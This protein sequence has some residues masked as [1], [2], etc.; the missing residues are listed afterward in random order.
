MRFKKVALSVLFLV[1]PFYS[2]AA[3]FDV[4]KETIKNAMKDPGSTEFRSLRNL[5]NSLGDTYVCGEVNSKNSY[6]GYV[7]FKGF[8]YK[9]GKF[10]IDGSFEEPSDAEFYAVSGCGGRD[11]EKVAIARKQATNGCK[12]TWEQITDIVLFGATPEK[13]AQNAIVK[14]K[15]I[16]PEIPPDQENQLKASFVESISHTLNDQNFVKSVKTET[17]AT[18]QA[19]MSGCIDATS[20]SLSGM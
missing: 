1:L 19:F 18:Q 10:V 8:A 12:I 14:L 3:D 5:K 13:A 9:P 4:A 7:G 2:V 15:V 16:N 20:K 11:L 17:K 6:G